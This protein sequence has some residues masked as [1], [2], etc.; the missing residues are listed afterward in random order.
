MPVEQ[1]A[2]LQFIVEQIGGKLG[3]SSKEAPIRQI[4]ADF[5]KKFE[6]QYGPVETR[7]IIGKGKV[8]K[9]ID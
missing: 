5:I 8:T 7:D 4:T 2:A 9:P 6:D 3:V 1:A